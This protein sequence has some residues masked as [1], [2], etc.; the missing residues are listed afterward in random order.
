MSHSE[1]QA[2]QGAPG[3]CSDRQ[4]RRES[5]RL[6]KICKP[7]WLA[8]LSLRQFF[9]CMTEGC[10]SR[11]MECNRRKFLASECNTHCSS[12]KATVVAGRRSADAPPT[13]A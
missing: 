11:N 6:N 13:M 7:A 5:A 2:R 8:D 1:L 10:S 3:G 4:S 9:I 12:L